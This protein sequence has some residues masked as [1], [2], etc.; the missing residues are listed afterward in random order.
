MLKDTF[1]SVN[2]IHNCV[3]A[4][5]GPVISTRLLIGQQNLTLN[6][7]AK[8]WNKACEKQINFLSIS[9]QKCEDSQIVCI[10]SLI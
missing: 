3:R 5:S 1:D 6:K 9:V 8:V 4:F 10:D 2:N 7:Y